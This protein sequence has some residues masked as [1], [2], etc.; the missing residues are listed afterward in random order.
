MKIIKNVTIY[1]C[2]HCGKELKTKHAMIKHEYLCFKNPKNCKACHF[3][4]H[5]EVVKIDVDFETYDGD[6]ITKKVKSFKC[7]LLDKLMFP[8]S[9]ERK[10]LHKKYETFSEQEPMPNYCEFI[11]EQ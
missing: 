2:E 10:E 11:E 9:I 5:L 1:K 8:Y 4:K 3:C 7:T 6:F